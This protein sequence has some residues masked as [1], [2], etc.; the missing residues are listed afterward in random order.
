MNNKL[1][2]EENIFLSIIS[3]TEKNSEKKNGFFPV[4]DPDPNQNEVIRKT[5]CFISSFMKFNG[6]LYLNFL[7]CFTPKNKSKRG[8]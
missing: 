7:K 3:F 6:S 1:I 4:M 5:A 2:N 8:N